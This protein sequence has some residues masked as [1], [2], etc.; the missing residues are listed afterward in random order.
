MDAITEA[1]TREAGNYG[2]RAGEGFPRITPEVQAL[3]DADASSIR[4]RELMP[5][6]GGMVKTSSVI[7]GSGAPQQSDPITSAL[8]AEANGSEKQPNLTSGRATDKLT[9]SLRERL[10]AMPTRGPK[11]FMADQ[12]QPSD[13]VGAASRMVRGVGANILGG[14]EGIRVLANGGSAADAQA[15][16]RVTVERGTGSPDTPGGE[17]IES[18]MQSPYNPLNWLGLV[19][20]KAGQA[21]LDVT[22]SP[23]LATAVDTGLNVAPMLWLRGGNRPMSMPKVAANETVRETTVLPAK[24]EAAGIPLGDVGKTEPPLTQNAHATQTEPAMA[25]KAAA[26]TQAP[27][28][29]ALPLV[30]LSALTDTTP[31]HGGL[32]KAAHPD[33]VSVLERIGLTRAR[34]SAIEGDALNGATDFQLSKFS[35]EPI[36]RAAAEQFTAEKSALKSHAEGIAQKT[37]GIVGMDEGAL[38][39]RGT[40]IADALTGLKNYFRNATR[41]LYAEADAKLGAQAFGVPEGFAKIINTESE[42]AGKS[43]NQ[44]LGNGIKAYLREQGIM[45]KDGAIRHVTVK[46][47]EGIKQYINSQYSHET[48][49]LSG[50]IKAALDNDVF[51]NAGAD[52]YSS[53]RQMH[54]QYMRTLGD[55]KGVSSIIDVDPRNPMNRAVALEK[56]P[57]T[58]TKMSNAQY[59]HLLK[60]LRE[61]PQELQP[62]AQ[63]AI[64]E[65]QAQWAEKLLQR[66]LGTTPDAMWNAPKV[67]NEIKL[68]SEKITNAFKDKPRLLADIKDLQEAGNILRVQMGYPGAAAQ[69]ANATKRGAMANLMRPIGA[70]T[71]GALGSIFGPAGAG[72]GALAGAEAGVRAGASMGE[73]AAL[74]RWN[75]GTTALKDIK[76]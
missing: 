71:G 66:G 52:V 63:K 4:Q 16:V 53:G 25:P 31:V 21:T 69:A 62:L 36:G 13:L 76:P 70:S 28:Q 20:A 39:A 50:K 45:D 41:A 22:G 42:F 46:E 29:A 5:D 2:K 23:A 65:I 61:M 68:N 44:S 32:P 12:I 18:A 35:E 26:V 64:S 40:G 75:K 58:V 55:P 57:D 37:G 60:T 11:E 54:A 27:K 51:A 3:R 24:A 49:G 17:K 47:V 10:N 9:G 30:D 8:M 48:A 74:N 6:G 72:A 67:T 34:N 43:T 59:D 73:R 56:I 1:L 15:A 19:A 33:R 14:Y 7:Q 38:I